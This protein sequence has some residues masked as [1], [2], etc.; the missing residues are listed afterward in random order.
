MTTS[1]RGRCAVGVTAALV[2]ALAA[3]PTTAEA[4]SADSQPSRG[5]RSDIGIAACPAAITPVTIAAGYD[6]LYTHYANTLTG[7]SVV[8]NASSLPL[9]LWSNYGSPIGAPV[10]SATPAGWTADT[11]TQQIK[12]GIPPGRVVLLPGEYAVLYRPAPEY[13]I[14]VVPFPVAQDAEFAAQYAGLAQA[15]HDGGRLIPLNN[16]LGTAINKC[17]E[18]ASGTWNQLGQA[19]GVE[20][21]ADIFDQARKLGS[22]KTAYNIINPSSTNPDKPPVWEKW[23][24]KV[25]GFNANWNTQLKDDIAARIA[26]ILGTVR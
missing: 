19:T 20:S 18:G 16:R 8:T 24:Q 14:D 1:Y 26:K 11:T 25:T 15:A 23:R 9:Q 5:P 4:V 22:C 3:A 10:H 7:C 12:L 6:G 21:L 2:L 17:A 13:T